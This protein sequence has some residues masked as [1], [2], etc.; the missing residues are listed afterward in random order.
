MNETEKVLASEID[1]L[2][3]ELRNLREDVRDLGRLCHRL[4]SVALSVSEQKNVRRNRQHFEGPH[5]GKCWPMDFQPEPS[6][7]PSAE[8]SPEESPEATREATPDSN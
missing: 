8:E 5:R 7:E 4:V 3:R 2:R 1:D 6:P